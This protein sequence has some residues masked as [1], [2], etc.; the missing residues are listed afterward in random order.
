MSSAGLGFQVSVGADLDRFIEHIDAYGSTHVPFVTA[1][2]L[3]KTAGDLKRAA[4]DEMAKVFDRP[5]RWTLNS[6][7]VKPATKNDL[8]ARVHFKDGSGVP[9]WKYLGPQVEGGPRAHKSHEQ[10]LIRAGV[11]RS[12]EYAVPGRGAK[13]DGYGNLAGSQIE[14]ILSQVK[15][16]ELYAGYRAN[17]TKR[18]QSRTMKRGR[19]FV[20]RPD[21]PVPPEQSRAIRKVF[22]GVYWRAAGQQQ[23][24]PVLMFVRAPVYRQRFR[25]YE[26]AEQIARD[27]T[28]RHFKDGWRQFVVGRGFA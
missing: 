25:Y 3:T 14:L 22:P 12:D 15:A 18:S 4:V 1:Y 7:Y 5:T 20:L 27:N 17:V 24:V 16:A 19:Y 8:S 21:W 6:L 11:M 2:A 26:L 10:R 23:I 13:L 9:A 28:L